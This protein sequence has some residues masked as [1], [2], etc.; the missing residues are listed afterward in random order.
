EKGE[1]ALIGGPANKE[2][3][4]AAWVYLRKEKATTWEYQAIIAGGKEESGEGEFGY[5]VSLSPKDGPKEGDLALIGGPANKEGIGA[6]WV[7]LRKEKAT[8]W[9]YQAIIAG[10]KE[11]SG[12]GEFGKS[13]AISAEG[14]NALI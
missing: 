11:E 4:G 14:T 8:T 7:Y 2:G 12:E 5:S 6:A 1:D 9:E 13:V 10:G 3:T